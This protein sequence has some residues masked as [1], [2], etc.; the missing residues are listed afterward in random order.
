MIK[1]LSKPL[2]MKIKR[3]D[4]VTVIAGKDK[5][6]Q[7]KVLRVLPTVNRVVVEGVNMV[8]KHKKKVPTA[9]GAQ[10]FGRFQMPAPL[11]ASNLMVVDK[12]TGKPTRVRR[13]RNAEG[14]LVRVSKAGQ[15]LDAES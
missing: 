14:K 2:R 3:G 6:K 5:G 12:D 11:H 13:A 15:I 7:G 8:T 9:K 4:T 10:E 1:K